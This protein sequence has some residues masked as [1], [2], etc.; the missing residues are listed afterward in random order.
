MLIMIFI[1]VWR[2]YLGKKDCN[3]LNY[4]VSVFLNEVL[5]WKIVLVNP[6]FFCLL[7]YLNDERTRLKKK[8]KNEEKNLKN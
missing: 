7:R 3:T 4:L 2:F 8:I 5:I 6:I 1:Q